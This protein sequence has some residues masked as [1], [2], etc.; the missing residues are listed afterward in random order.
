MILALKAE[1]SWGFR[2]RPYLQNKAD[3]KESLE[4]NGK[5]PLGWPMNKTHRIIKPIGYAEADDGNC[6]LES[7]ERSPVLGG[8][9][10][11]LISW[12]VRAVEIILIAESLVRRL[13]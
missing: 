2:K 5:S 11:A 13:A 7:Q 9:E 8:A 6:P 3:G 10:L 12:D 4:C 1:V